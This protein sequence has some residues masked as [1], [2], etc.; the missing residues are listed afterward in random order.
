MNSEADEA[1][2]L[3]RYADGPKQLERA[4]DG[5]D[6]SQLDSSRAKGKWTVRQIVHH[7]VDGDDLWKLGIKSAL[8][9]EDAEFTLG[10]Y[11]TQSQDAWAECWRY[12][13]RSVDVSLALFRAIREHVVQLVQHVPD[14]WE[15]SIS[16]RIPDGRT[17]RITVGGVIKMQADHVT[18][19][20]EQIRETVDVG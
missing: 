9:N 1:A 8:G 15:R 17:E 7:I 16:V 6:E 20:I 5:L 11:G 18:H 4:V 13:E 12:S 19:H 3:A 2:V 10:W 14:A